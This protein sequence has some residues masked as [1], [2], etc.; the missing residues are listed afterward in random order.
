MEVQTC[1]CDRE[2][3]KSVCHAECECEAWKVK[4]RTPVCECVCEYL[5][6]EEKW[7]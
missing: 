5:W 2:E 6:G 1:G 4:V 3:I 7:P